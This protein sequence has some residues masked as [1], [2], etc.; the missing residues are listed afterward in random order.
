MGADNS[1]LVFKSQ[2]LSSLTGN[3][4]SGSFGC[5][6]QTF[7]ERMRRAREDYAK[8]TQEKLSEISG[9]AQGTISKIERGESHSSKF[10]VRL[11][12]ACGVR[13]EWLESGA[14]P[15]LQVKGYATS[16]PKLIAILKLMEDKAEYVK[17]AA[18]KE[19]TQMVEL[20][21]HTRAGSNNSGTHG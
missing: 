8:L 6:N 17:D 14:E 16:D 15:M 11:A 3:Y 10:T 7:G 2:Y 12:L 9:V 21:E 1:R 20:V 19:I 18:I 13:P 4:Y 5:M